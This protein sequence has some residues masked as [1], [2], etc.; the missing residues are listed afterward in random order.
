MQA[1]MASLMGH[2][3]KQE[4]GGNFFCFHICLQCKGEKVHKAEDGGIGGW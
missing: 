1:I 3:N 2:A 4:G